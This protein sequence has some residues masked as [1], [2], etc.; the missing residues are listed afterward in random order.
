[1]FSRWFNTSPPMR[2]MSLGEKR[3]EYFLRRGIRPMR[4]NIG[5]IHPD[6]LEP[7]IREMTWLA[8]NV[9]R[10]RKLDVLEQPFRRTCIIR[11]YHC[12]Y[13]AIPKGVALFTVIGANRL[14]YFRCLLHY[15]GGSI[16]K[17]RPFQPCKTIDYIDKATTTVCLFATLF[18]LSNPHRRYI[19]YHVVQHVK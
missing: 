3:E 17:C 2:L 14:E 19:S 7:P 18:T 6:L 16:S 15:R 11:V 4:L 12:T 1:M 10:S 13:H 9:S 5:R 8:L